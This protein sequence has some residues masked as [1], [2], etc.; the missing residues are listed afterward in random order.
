MERG[1]TIADRVPG[2]HRHN[3]IGVHGGLSADEMWVPHIHALC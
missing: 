3:M 1:W 2:E